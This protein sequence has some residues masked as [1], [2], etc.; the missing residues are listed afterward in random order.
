MTDTTQDRRGF[1]FGIRVGEKN[2]T[3]TLSVDAASP[4]CAITALKT[5]LMKLEEGESR[6]AEGENNVMMIGSVAATSR[7]KLHQ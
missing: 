2:K 7:Y 6:F 5:A 4:S 1:L 3:Y